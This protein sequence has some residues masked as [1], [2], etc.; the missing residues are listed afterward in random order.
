MYHAN[1]VR[2]V[3]AGLQEVLHQEQVPME[4]PALIEEPVDHVANQ[5]QKT[6][7]QLATQLQQTQEM[8]QEMQ[9]QY[10][11]GPHN[12]RQ[13]YGGLRYH[14]G[15]TNYCGQGG[16]GAKLRVNWWDGRGGRINRDITHYCWTH[17]MCAHQ[18]KHCR[19]PE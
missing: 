10:A 14:I 15:H 5:V 3:V 7:K 19:N 4:N 12:A 8:I 16:R 13:D 18:G 2:D 9:I 1:M 6:Q 17:G 11:A